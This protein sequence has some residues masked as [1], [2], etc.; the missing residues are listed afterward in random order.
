MRK[1]LNLEPRH[2]PA[3]VL[4][5]RP[6]VP[7]AAMWAVALERTMLTYFELE[8][9]ACFER[10]GHASEQI[11]MV[12]EGELFF[13]VNGDDEIAVRTGEVIAVPADVPHAVRT[14]DRPARAVDAW[15]PIRS[16]LLR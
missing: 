7:G 14:G 4:R 9:H 11:T 6:D 12:L 3:D 2:F 16:D 10:H 15:S 5:L 13:E 1:R 8:P